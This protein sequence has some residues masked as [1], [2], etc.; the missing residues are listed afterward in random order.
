[1]PDRHRS[2]CPINLA[3]EILGDRWS[4]IVLR[5]MT[6]GNQRHFRDLLNNSMEGIA[7]NILADRLRKLEEAAIIEKRRDPND[8]RRYLYR[9]SP[10]GIDLAPVLVELVIWSARH[11]RTDAPAAVVRSMRSDKAA[12]IA[13]IQQRLRQDT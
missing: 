5:D 12:Y 13:G 10:R 1:M 11:A 2:G 7:S 3:L 8:A 4:L 6:F 9:L